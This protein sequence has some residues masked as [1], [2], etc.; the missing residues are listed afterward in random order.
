MD[1][2]DYKNTCPIRFMVSGFMYIK[3]WRMWIIEEFTFSR[4]KTPGQIVSHD[5]TTVRT[6][7]SLM[8]LCILHQRY[9]CFIGA[10]SFNSKYIKWLAK[11]CPLTVRSCRAMV[12]RNKPIL[13]SPDRNNIVRGIIIVQQKLQ[14]CTCV[15]ANV[16]VDAY[17]WNPRGRNESCESSSTYG[18]SSY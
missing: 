9:T 17:P 4:W 2:R 16:R 6:V 1:Q 10:I 15:Y 7:R 3:N 14:A 18:L 11:A 5:Q 8:R 12:L 13:N